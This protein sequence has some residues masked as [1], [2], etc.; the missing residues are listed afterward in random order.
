MKIAFLIGGIVML[1]AATAWAL[2]SSGPAGTAHSVEV[3]DV[4]GVPG[5]V[6][7]PEVVAAVPGYSAIPEVVVRANQMPEVV[8]R[9]S[10]PIEVAGLGESGSEFLN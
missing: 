10:C 5:L 6:V 2:S 1:V 7:S 8:V 4:G 3:S 9:A